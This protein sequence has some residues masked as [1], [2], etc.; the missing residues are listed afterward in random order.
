MFELPSNVSQDEIDKFF[1]NISKNVKQIR[2][3]KGYSQLETALSIGYK[4]QGFYA[5][6]ENYSHKKHFNLI[7]LLKLSKFF[8]VDIAEFFKC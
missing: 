8:E 4:S 1:K 6:L 2:V 7:H 5:S 3:N